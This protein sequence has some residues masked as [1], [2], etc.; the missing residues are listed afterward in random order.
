[1]YAIRS[2]YGTDLSVEAGS[3]LI[4]NSNAA[5]TTMNITLN[6]GATGIIAG[7]ISVMCDEIT[8]GSNHKINSKVDA[9]HF[10]SGSVFHA[11]TGFASYP[12]GSSPNGGVVFE[13]GSTYRHSSGDTP[14]GGTNA[15][16][17][18]V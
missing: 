18:V 5:S 8:T 13:S 1:M 7:Q 12:F 4:L 6:T 9:L 10:V 17:V 3:H 16:N 14:F 11:T 15:T 2:Y